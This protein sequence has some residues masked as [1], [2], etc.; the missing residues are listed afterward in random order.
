M[1]AYDHIPGLVLQDGEPVF[2]EPWEAS[3]FALVVGLHEKNVFAWSEWAEVLGEVLKNESPG[4]PYYQSWLQALEMILEQKTVLNADEIASRSE[5]WAAAVKATP[6]GQPI[7]LEN[8]FAK[9]G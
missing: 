9:R 1:S 7:E 5:E 4:T 6:H 8:G 3:A 2:S